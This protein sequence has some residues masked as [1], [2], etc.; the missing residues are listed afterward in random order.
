M[1]KRNSRSWVGEFHRALIQTVS[2]GYGFRVKRSHFIS[3]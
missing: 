1:N 2:G 3:Q